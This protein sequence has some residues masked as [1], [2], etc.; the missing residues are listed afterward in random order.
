VTLKTGWHAMPWLIH[1]PSLSPLSPF[2]WGKSPLLSRPSNLVAAVR[3]LSV[4]PTGACCC[5]WEAGIPF[6]T[7]LFA[8]LSPAWEVTLS[9]V[10]HSLERIRAC[11]DAAFGFSARV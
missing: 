3:G 8:G 10:V 4:S 1:F 5:W 6:L 9:S 2:E 7:P 11:M